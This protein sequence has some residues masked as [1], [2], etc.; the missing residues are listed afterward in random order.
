MEHIDTGVSQSGQPNFHFRR[1]LG[2]LGGVI[3][4]LPLADAQQQREIRADCGTT[5]LD[6]F[7]RKAGAIHQAVSAPHVGSLVCAVPEELVNQIA[8]GA[9][10]LCDVEAEVLGAPHRGCVSGD[11]VCD[12]RL[13]HGVAARIIRP[14]QPGGTF[15][16]HAGVPVAASG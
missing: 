5:G 6:D 10:Q 11:G 3:L 2:Q 8:V 14:N 16:G 4:L 15:N 12:I 1:S 9:V 7:Q 13:A